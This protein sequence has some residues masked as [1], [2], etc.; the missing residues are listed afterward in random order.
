[1][2]RRIHKSAW[3]SKK[4]EH[5]T[6]PKIMTRGLAGAAAL[7]LA[8]TASSAMAAQFV[9]DFEELNNS[10]VEGTGTLFYDEGAGTL[11]VTINATG[12]AEGAHLGHIHGRFDNA[13]NPI[14]SVVPPPSADD[15]GDG[16][17]ELEEG[18]E[19]YGPILLPL[20]GID[21]VGA[22]GILNYTQTFDLSEMGIFAEGFGAE[23]LFPL[24][25]REIVLHGGPVDP[26]AGAGTGGII[27]GTQGSYS[28][29]L[30]V[31][32]GGI[33]AAVPEPETWAMMLLGFFGIGAAM[34]RAK[35][36]RPTRQSVSYS[37]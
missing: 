11:T 26:N 4:E 8:G 31:A 25:F 27:D 10:G 29:A 3:R 1:M 28:V 12:L 15:D 30:P 14:D 32:A 16:F 18:A 6:R 22:D 5:M 2:K 24:T 13:G 20:S 35:P 9:V 34:R 23:D 33:M 37:W 36:A 7:M 17:I 19:F 21:Q